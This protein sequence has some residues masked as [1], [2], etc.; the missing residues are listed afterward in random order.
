M[1]DEDINDRRNL[2]DF[3]LKIGGI[4]DV[5]T[6]PKVMLIQSYTV[7]G[8]LSINNQLQ[9]YS[10]ITYV[11]LLKQCRGQGLA[12]QLLYHSIDVAKQ[13]E[14]DFS[15][16][17]SS[18]PHLQEYYHKLGWAYQASLSYGKWRVHLASLEKDSTNDKR[19]VRSK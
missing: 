18:K 11:I 19:C 3:T 6:L 5:C 10:Y 1:V 2:R 14:C 9:E 16:L 12:R 7:L 8:N 13:N 15:L 17:H 4:G